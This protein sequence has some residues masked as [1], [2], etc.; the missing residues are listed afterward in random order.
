MRLVL[1]ALICLAGCS[2]PPTGKRVKAIEQNQFG[3]W[4]TLI[5]EV[6]GEEY[7][8]VEDGGMLQLPRQTRIVYP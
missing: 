7:L 2:E 4:R 3:I 8:V 5:I 1:L 6:D